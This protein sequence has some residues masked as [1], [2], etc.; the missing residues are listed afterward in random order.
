[1]YRIKITTSTLTSVV[2]FY[3][4]LPGS[5][6]YICCE[7]IGITHLFIFLSLQP[8][9]ILSMISVNDCV[10][11]FV[12]VSLLHQMPPEFFFVVASFLNWD[13]EGLEIVIEKLTLW[14]I[15]S[16]YKNSNTH[17]QTTEQLC[18]NS[19]NFYN[20]GASIFENWKMRKRTISNQPISFFHQTGQKEIT[21]GVD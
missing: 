2:D 16:T 5:S 7:I 17:W 9:E 10:N 14:N 4:F 20:C 12:N 8:V 19:E 11:N 13:L 21:F 6:I 15:R 18:K 1:M 3:Q